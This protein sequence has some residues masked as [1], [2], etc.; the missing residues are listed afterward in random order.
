M[1]WAPLKGTIDPIGCI[2]ASS[3]QLA[4]TTWLH[5][6][7]CM[8]VVVLYFR[9]GKSLWIVWL[10]VAHRLVLLAANRCMH[11]CA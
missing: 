8:F 2:L 4:S 11:G 6:C 9:L 3:N 7:T 1:F 10:K 5:P